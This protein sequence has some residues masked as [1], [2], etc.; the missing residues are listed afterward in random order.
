M[1]EFTLF[2]KL[3]IELRFRIWGIAAKVP[4][5]VRLWAESDVGHSG[6]FETRG[7][8]SNVPDQSRH[9]A[10]MR[11][12]RESYEEGLRYYSRVQEISRIQQKQ[13]TSRL[14][15]INNVHYINFEIDTFVHETSPCV[16]QSFRRHSRRRLQRQDHEKYLF[17][18]MDM[19]STTAAELRKSPWKG[20]KSVSLEIVDWNDDYRIDSKLG[21]VIRYAIQNKLQD[22]VDT[23][24]D[25]EGVSNDQICKLHL[26]L[27]WLREGYI[28]LCPFLLFSGLLLNIGEEI[29]KKV[30]TKEQMT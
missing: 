6:P 4:R 28:D 12:C 19:A 7:W 27:I 24:V 23:I 2:S 9:P 18:L 10:I 22:V 14:G 13:W 21:K 17:Y 8:D 11:A 5:T 15:Y 26:N 3:P 20:V 30:A 29:W 16:R 1:T 25:G